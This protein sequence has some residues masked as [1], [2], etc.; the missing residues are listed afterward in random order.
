MLSQVRTLAGKLVKDTFLM[1]MIDQVDISEKNEFLFYPKLGNQVIL[2]GNASSLDEKF[3]KLKLFYK[4]VISKTGWQHYGLIN[5]TFRNQVI[6]KIRGR[7]DVVS[8][9]LR[10]K[11]I[12]D[13][14]A[15]RSQ[16]MAADSALTSNIVVEKI[17]ADISMIQGSIERD[18]DEEDTAAIV[19]IPVYPPCLLYT[20]PSPRD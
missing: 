12:M 2:V 17:P 6:A 8:D 7:E 4:N 19:S 16:E 3:E 18:A 14:I 1:S 20:S 10:A 15:K 5:L 13:Y 11:Q 9:S